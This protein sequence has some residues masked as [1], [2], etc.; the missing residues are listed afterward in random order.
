MVS[1]DTTAKRPVFGE[2]VATQI[3]GICA[4]IARR[5]PV[6]ICCGPLGKVMIPFTPDSTASSRAA[7]SK[8]TVNAYGNVKVLLDRNWVSS[9]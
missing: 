7:K 3:T 9:I 6:R 5:I 1:M 8:T 2:S 4:L